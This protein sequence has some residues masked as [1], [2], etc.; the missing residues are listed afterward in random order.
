[1]GG[2]LN[3]N[4]LIYTTLSGGSDGCTVADVRI[5]LGYT[6]VML[7]NGSA[8]VAYTFRAEA[9]DGCTIFHGKRP[10][11]GRPA[12][13]LLSHLKS[14]DLVEAAVGLATANALANVGQDGA[15]QGDLLDAV[16]L[17]PDD[18]VG[19]VGFFAPLI[20]PIKKRAKSLTI[21]ERKRMVNKDVLPREAMD[22]M[23]P[24]CTV[25]IITSTAILNHTIDRILELAASCRE[26]VMLGASTPLL[27]E[28]FKAT[29]VTCLSGVVVRRPEEI[30]QIVS[31]GGGMRMFGD[32]VRKMNL[33][34]SKEHG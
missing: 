33:I 20:G 31:E 15:V 18:S 8:G 12:G 13:E 34:R 30:L 16:E 11:A 26:V 2:R 17:G 28:L 7:D 21:F 14:S 22:E 9:S 24:R 29:P 25:A 3:I 4:D 10:L 5:G 1:M 32:S 19:M 27:G 6:A 23:L